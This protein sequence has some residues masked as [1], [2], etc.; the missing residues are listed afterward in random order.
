M[1]TCA[2]AGGE[3]GDASGAKYILTAICCFSRWPWLVPIRD[4]TAE[5]VGRALLER[6]LIGMAMFPTVIRSDNDPTFLSELFLYMNRMLNI[7]HITG[8][9]YHPQSQGLVEGMHKTLNIMLRKLIENNAKMWESMLPYA[10]CILRIT[11]LESLMG[12]SP[13]QVVTGLRPKLPRAMMGSS[14]AIEPV[15]IDEYVGNLIGYLRECY[16]SI[17]QQAVSIRE[18]KEVMAREEG[19]LGMELEVG[20]VVMMKL[21]PTVRREGPKRFQSRVRDE[22]YVIDQKVSPHTF[23]VKTY[24]SPQTLVPGTQHAE[25]LVRVELPWVE[26]D[27]NGLRIIE[28]FRNTVGD[29]ARYRIERYA[30]DG[31]CLLKRMR[32]QDGSDQWTEDGVGTWSDLSVELYRWVV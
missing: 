20:D 2:D 4:K 6:V 14:N 24:W 32:Q 21:D 7:K 17:R 25:N 10:E 16:S 27:P 13:Y 3:E 26:L 23:R 12:R 29:W 9:T 28:I 15:G 22:L 31:R 11:P 18:V 30:P 8:S 19:T 1:V 5:T